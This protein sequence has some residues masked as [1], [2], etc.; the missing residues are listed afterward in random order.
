VGQRVEV[1]QDPGSATPRSLRFSH[2][3]RDLP[4]GRHPHLVR[5][6]QQD[7]HVA[8]ASPICVVVDGSGER[9][10]RAVT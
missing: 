1:H 6:T 3:V 10:I 2:L 5:V 8:W 9:G 4:A 7:G